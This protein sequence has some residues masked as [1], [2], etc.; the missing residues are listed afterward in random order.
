MKYEL[1]LY[2]DTSSTP[3][4]QH[5]GNLFESDAQ[6]EAL[7]STEGVL[8]LNAAAW[9]FDLEKSRDKYDRILSASERWGVRLM[10][11][12]LP[13]GLVYSLF[14]KSRLGDPTDSL[15]KVEGRIWAFFS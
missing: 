4:Q 3:E 2:I 14:P 6:L 11:I 7:K 9:I 13:D 10:T 8:W 1:V 15:R 12:E 5:V